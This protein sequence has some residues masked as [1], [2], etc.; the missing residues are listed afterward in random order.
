VALAA[1]ADA[2]AEAAAERNRLA[3]QAGWIPFLGA[4]QAAA[5]QNEAA[6]LTSLEEEV[7]SARLRG[8]KR[9]TPSAPE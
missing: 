2:L 3:A 5:A 7:N 9:E 6:Q 8:A 4:R 1:I